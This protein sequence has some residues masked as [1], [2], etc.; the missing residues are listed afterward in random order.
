MDIDVIIKKCQ[1]GSKEAFNDL[2]TFYY[3]FVRKFLLKL[4][5]NKELSDDLTQDVFIK[6][7]RNIDKFSLSG[8]ASFSTYIITIAKNCYIDNLRKNKMEYQEFDFDVI[9]DK[10]NIEC[11]TLRHEDYNILLEKIDKLP[12]NQKEAIKLK[13]LEGYTLCEIA[14]I[15]NVEVKTIKSRL[16]EGRKKLK[17]ELEGADIYE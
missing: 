7:I 12:L 14:K 13:Y 16:F 3:P 2:V 15:Q 6:I 5:A 1:R 9:P 17:K 10:L 11:D 8:K 4:T